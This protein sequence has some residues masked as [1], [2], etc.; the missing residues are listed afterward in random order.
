MSGLRFLA[1][2]I[3]ISVPSLL[4]AAPKTAAHK[5][6]A[7]ASK[8][9]V[10]RAQLIAQDNRIFDRA[11]TDHDGYMS[12]AEFAARMAGVVNASNPPSKADAQRMVDGANRAFDNADTNHD[13]KLSRAEG[14]AR[15]LKAFDV[16]DL[17]HDGVLTVAE[18]RAAYQTGPALQSGPV[19][20]AAGK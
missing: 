12:R 6:V 11:D 14:T 13:G 2:L 18:K 4:A 7:P 15:P 1:P 17:N 16:M 9:D 5:P 3:L 19:Q 20:P 8:G 10:T